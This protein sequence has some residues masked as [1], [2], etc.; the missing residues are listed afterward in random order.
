MLLRGEAIPP[1]CVGLTVTRKIAFCAFLIE[2][3]L[4]C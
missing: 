4:R 2:K 3:G 1:V